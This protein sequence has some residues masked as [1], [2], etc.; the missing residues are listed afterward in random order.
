MTTC[1]KPHCEIEFQQKLLK[2]RCQSTEHKSSGSP[3]LISLGF[4]L[5][6]SI[7]HMNKMTLPRPRLQD[8]LEEGTDM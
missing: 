4:V 6:F 2:H 5:F 8:Q 7:K 1:N 3:D